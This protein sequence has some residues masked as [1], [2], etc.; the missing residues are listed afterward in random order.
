MHLLKSIR[1]NWLTEKTGQL[2]F[3]HNGAFFLA[4]WSDL[5]ML[6]KTECNSLF[7]LSK[8]TAKSLYPKPIERQSVKLCLC[9]FCEETVAAFR[10]HP[11]IENK[12][13]EGTA[14]FIEKIISFWSVVNANAAGAGICFRNELCGEIHSV[15]DRQLQLLH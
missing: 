12:A 15:D 13:F 11:D 1:N 4:K 5:E 6:Y 9:V 7:K 14:I 3:L 2:Q 10:T 8:L